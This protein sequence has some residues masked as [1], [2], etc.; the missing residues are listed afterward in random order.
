[1]FYGHKNSLDK[2]LVKYIED[3]IF[4]SIKIVIYTVNASN[5]FIYLA[6]TSA[7]LHNSDFYKMLLLKT[8]YMTPCM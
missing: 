1:M 3:V 2:G 8:S 5:T 7:N 6:Q 4:F